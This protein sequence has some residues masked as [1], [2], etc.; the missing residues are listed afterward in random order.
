MSTNAGDWRRNIARVLAQ[1]TDD[2]VRD[3]VA[4]YQEFHGVA[5]VLTRV[6]GLASVAHGAGVLA[7]LSP[8][9][10]WDDNVSDAFAVAKWWTVRRRWAPTWTVKRSGEG[11]DVVCPPTVRTTHPNRLKAQR[12]ASS[13]HPEH[14]LRGLKIRAFYLNIVSPLA[15]LGVAVDRH[16]ACAAAGRVMTEHQV[17]ALLRLHYRGIERTY[18]DLA[19][20]EGLLGNQLASVVWFAWR[21]MKLAGTLS[22]A[23]LILELAA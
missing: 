7:A 23:R 1:A 12:I 11:V 3:G 15:G 10:N 14:V 9:N 19:A 8:M 4:F 17:S 5:R 20:R 16:L 22:Q 21:R 18:V 6:Y 13:E 2:D